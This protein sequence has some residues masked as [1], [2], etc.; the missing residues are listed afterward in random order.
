MMP[1]HFNRTWK[2]RH[3]RRVFNAVYAVAANAIGH[4]C[5][6]RI[7]VKLALHMIYPLVH[8][9]YRCNSVGVILVY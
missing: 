5:L 6:T 4:H 8:A 1:S 9:V 7:Q 3:A 2:F